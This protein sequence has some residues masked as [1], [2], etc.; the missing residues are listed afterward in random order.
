MADAIA[1]KAEP[2]PEK[3]RAVSPFQSLQDEMERMIHAFSRPEINWHSSYTKALEEAQTSERPLLVKV[4]ATWCG[5]CTKMNRETLS[6]DAVAQEINEHFVALELDADRDRELISK[7]RVS[8]FP[9]TIVVAPDRRILRRI[10]GYQG[11]AEFTSNLRS[12]LQ[13]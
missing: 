1:R 9:T 2:E 7:F 4:S 8:S 6:D 5:Y 13:R 3:S 10:S 12:T 11:K